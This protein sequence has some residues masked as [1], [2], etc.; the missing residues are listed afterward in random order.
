MAGSPDSGPIVPS[1]SDGAAAVV[2]NLTAADPTE[3]GYVVA[4]PGPLGTP[5]PN[6]STVNFAPGQT[7]ASLAVSGFQTD[8]RVSVYN[9][10][11]N[12][13]VIT[14]L[15]GFFTSAGF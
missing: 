12:T 4:Y 11:G 13:H 1:L 2:F 8:G 7:A 6:T 3:G 5:P 9:P 10:A 15:A 14:D